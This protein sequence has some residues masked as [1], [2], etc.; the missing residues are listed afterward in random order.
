MAKW[1][2]QSETTRWGEGGRRGGGGGGRGT[3]TSLEL[4]EARRE[5]IGSSY[6]DVSFVI[7]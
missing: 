3:E 2:N 1:D 7:V 5:Q 6:T 4:N